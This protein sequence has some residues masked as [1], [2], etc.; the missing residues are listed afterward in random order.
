MYKEFSRKKCEFSR[1]LYIFPLILMNYFNF[2]AKNNFSLFDSFKDCAFD[3]G[4]LYR[5]KS[6]E[7]PS[8]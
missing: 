7:L 5:T 6:N 2:Q 1:K 4:I 8:G 3:F